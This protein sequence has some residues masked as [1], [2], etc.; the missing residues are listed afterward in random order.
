MC[1]GKNKC[2]NAYAYLM[3]NVW[4]VPV[5]DC[6]EILHLCTKSNRVDL[7]EVASM[8]N[9]KQISMIFSSAQMREKRNKI[10]KRKANKTKPRSGKT[11]PVCA[12]SAAAGDGDG[13]GDG[14]YISGNNNSA[15]E[16]SPGVSFQ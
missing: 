14:D 2:Y 7:T 3:N 10:E 5:E 12:A 6:S 9:Y 13:D 16:A 11:M 8:P 4:V 15:Q 1:R